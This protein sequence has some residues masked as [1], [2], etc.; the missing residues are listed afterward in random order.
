M[1]VTAVNGSLEHGVVGPLTI[2]C[3]NGAWIDRGVDIGRNTDR[4]LDVEQVPA[5]LGGKDQPLG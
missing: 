1:A 2:G 4:V 5:R 3:G